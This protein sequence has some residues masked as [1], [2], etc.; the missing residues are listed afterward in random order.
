MI[1]IKIE[2]NRSNE[3]VFKIGTKNLMDKEERFLKR[4]LIDGKE[5]T[6]RY[7][8]E[9]PLKYFVPIINNIGKDNIKLDKHSK[10]SYLE[11]SDS[12]DEKYYYTLEA[13]AKYMKKW[14]EEDCPNIFKI[15]INT[16]TLEISKEIVFKKINRTY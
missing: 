6:G 1:K 3:P 4:A 11:F 5:I 13:N 9:I 12:F 8:Y 2:K 16:D 15:E 14:R 10:V 7:N